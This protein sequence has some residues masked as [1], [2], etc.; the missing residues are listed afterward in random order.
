MT[1]LY[2]ETYFAEFMGKPFNADLM[3]GSSPPDP[4]NN[5]SSSAEAPGEATEGRG[6]EVAKSFK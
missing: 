5:L 4:L 3:E 6:L 2:K 1:Q